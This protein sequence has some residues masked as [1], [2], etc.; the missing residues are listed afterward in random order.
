MIAARELLDTSIGQLQTLT[1]FLR[2]QLGEGGHGSEFETA[3]R[4]ACNELLAYLPVL[5]LRLEAA[6][7]DLSAGFGLAGY[8]P[9]RMRRTE[10][11]E[12]FANV[13]GGQIATNRGLASREPVIA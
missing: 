13:D 9:A 8:V 4:R 3:E 10:A 1:A 7:P 11:D 2:E 5:I 6:R 12:L